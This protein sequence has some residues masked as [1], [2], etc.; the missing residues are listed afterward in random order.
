MRLYEEE[1]ENLE[2]VLSDFLEKNYTDLDYLIIDDI[3][4][5]GYQ[6]LLL[7][8]E[9]DSI[10]IP[11]SILFINDE[12]GN[13]D[14]ALYSDTENLIDFDIDN[15]DEVTYL[16]GYSFSVDKINDCMSFIQEDIKEMAKAQYNINLEMDLQ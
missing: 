10:N 6:A 12:N 16:D 4:H 14:V 8:I 5:N 2:G 15:D 9:H 11:Q 13:I 1:L 3:E 7:K